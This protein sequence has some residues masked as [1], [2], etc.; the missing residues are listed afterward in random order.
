MKKLTLIGIFSLLLAACGQNQNNIKA[1]DSTK[2]KI[3]DKQLQS[4]A[5]KAVVWAMPIISVDAM[6]QAFFRDAHAKQNDVVFLGKQPDWKFQVTTPNASTHYIYVALDTKSG[7]VVID[8][9][10]AVGAGLFGSLLDGWQVP[11]ADVGPA[12]GDKGKGGKYLLIPPGYKGDIP[13][14][15]YFPVQAK[16]YKG[17]AIFRAIPEGTS[18]TEVQ[19]AMDLVKKI[20]LYP[21]SQADNPP[22]SNHIDISGKLFDGIVKFD[23]TIFTRMAIALKDEP[24]QAR[25]TIMMEQLKLLGIEK[26]KEFNPDSSMSKLLRRA[27]QNALSTFMKNTV[28]EGAQF[29]DNQW[30]SPSVVGAKT[31]FT[32]IVND[33]LDVNARGL[34]YFLACAPPVKLGKGSFYLSTFKDGSGEF[35]SGENTY[36]FQVPPHVPASQFWASTVYD[37][38]SCAFIRESLKIEL[39][40]YNKEMNKNTDGSVDIYYGPKA[41]PG[42]EKNWIYTVPGKKWFTIFRLYGPQQSFFDKTWK[43]G[44]V[45][46]IK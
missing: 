37:T 31:A 9:P 43:M 13:V 35:L 28:K 33:S 16:T 4:I 41:P 39:S 11:L 12:G 14:S 40:S 19:K 2:I 38:E 1:V 34:V 27:A 21:F 46:K 3:T 24:V 6:N 25:D 17:Y 5:E 29:W 44:D 36:H 42:K 8:I 26:G 20:N 7:P 32:F 10:A 23:E 45:E 30:K 22:G 18:D 15:G